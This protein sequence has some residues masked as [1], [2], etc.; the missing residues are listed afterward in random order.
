MLKSYKYDITILVH[1]HF[2]TKNIT[3]ISEKSKDESI[4]DE[5]KVKYLPLY[6]LIHRYVVCQ[7]VSFHSFFC[8]D[9]DLRGVN[10]HI[11]V[12]GFGKTLRMGF[13]SR[14]LS[15]MHG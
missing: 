5:C 3:Q 13:F 12:T 9:L 14:K 10:I 8:P 4:E 7:N 11:I 2:K 15:L 6:A 1:I